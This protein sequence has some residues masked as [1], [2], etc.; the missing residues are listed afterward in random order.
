MRCHAGFHCAWMGRELGHDVLSGKRQP[1]SARAGSAAGSTAFVGGE[2]GGGAGEQ[3]RSLRVARYAMVRDL[4]RQA[5]LMV[6]A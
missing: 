1:P 6:I 5:M 3:Q 4:M 2:G